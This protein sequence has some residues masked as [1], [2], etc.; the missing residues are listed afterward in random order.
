MPK[1]QLPAYSP[2]SVYPWKNQEPP[3]SLLLSHSSLVPLLK[4]IIL[5]IATIQALSL[6]PYPKQIIPV[7]SCRLPRLPGLPRPRYLRDG[8][9]SM[10]IDTTLGM[11]FPILIQAKVLTIAQV[12]CRPCHGQIAMG[13]PRSQSSPTII[14]QC[15]ARR[16]S[17]SSQCGGSEETHGIKQPL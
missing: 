8:Q 4:L 10:T 12:L 13:P 16:P 2:L 1:P 9:R 17:S 15:R 14:Q 6:A 7:I 3:H 5:T 11:Y